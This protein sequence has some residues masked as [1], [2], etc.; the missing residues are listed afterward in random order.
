MNT[1]DGAAGRML[2]LLFTNYW[3]AS[4]ILAA[5]N[6]GLADAV[7]EA[8]RD[9]EAIARAIGAHPD[10]VYR[11]LRDLAGTGIFKETAPR[12]FVNTP[13]SAALRRDAADHVGATIRALGLKSTREAMV[14]YEEA[15]V[16]GRSAFELAHGPG[17]VTPFD[18]L[19]SRPDEAAL[20][21]E[22]MAAESRLAPA[23]LQR[24]D[25]GG[26]RTLVDVGGGTGTFLAR[27]LQ[28][29]PAQRGVLFDS[30]EV[31]ST[32]ALEECGV[33]ARCVVIPGDMRT[34]V[35]AGGDGY[36]LKNILH[37]WPD[38]ECVALLRRIRQS[39]AAGAR[40][41]IIENVMPAA[42]D[43][44]PCKVFDLFLLLGGTHS[45]VRSE[46]EMRRLL[47]QAGFTCSAVVNLVA[48]QCLIEGT[49]A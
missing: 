6:L 48:N 27:I 2:L 37:G 43:P 22:G 31:V 1:H 17:C 20:Y 47:D 28:Q 18:V 23:A 12:H 42:N 13:L 34:E 38:E 41:L 16:T 40:V 14:R 44:A 10:C 7:D 25:F 5:A 21:R 35:P 19:A 33:A 15:I 39:A 49:A 26:I 24:Y 4:A 8:P 46:A 45:R 29:H 32:K 3:L 11:L 30:S 36:L 9:V